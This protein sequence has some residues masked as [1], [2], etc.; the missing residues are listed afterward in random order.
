M[1]SRVKHS[2]TRAVPTEDWA[3]LDQPEPGRAGSNQAEQGRSLAA[4]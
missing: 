3:E 4:I 1:Y 2:Q